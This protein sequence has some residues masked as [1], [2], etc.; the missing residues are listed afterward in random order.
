M[1]L[2]I[3]QYR[4]MSLTVTPPE[5]LKSPLTIPKK[6]MLGLGPGYL[7]GSLGGSLGVS[8]VGSLGV[9]LVGS[10]GCCLGGSLDSSLGGS[11]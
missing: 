9:S 8:L 2:F 11:F 7:R 3:Q 1:L 4:N 5:S 6:T 10:L